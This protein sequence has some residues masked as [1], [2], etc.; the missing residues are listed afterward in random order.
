[1]QGVT[2]VPQRHP[3]NEILGTTNFR[4]R[5]D[6]ALPAVGGD[7]VDVDVLVH[8]HN[9]LAFWVN[10][11]QHLL[12]VHRLHHLADIRTLLLKKLELLTK[13]TNL[14]KK[15]FKEIIFWHFYWY[16]INY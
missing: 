11:D 7:V 8:V 16:I 9:K 2:V 3:D 5:F 6:F 1:M 10:L 13:H 4:F 15:I 12:F 14:T